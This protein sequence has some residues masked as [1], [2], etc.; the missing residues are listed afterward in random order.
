MF[1]NNQ[2][3]ICILFMLCYSLLDQ[4]I[5]YGYVLPEILIECKCADSIIFALP[6]LI[7]IIDYAPRADYI[8]IIMAE[9]RAILA[10]TKPVQVNNLHECVSSFLLLLTTV[11]AI[12]CLV[13]IFLHANKHKETCNDNLYISQ[14][15]VAW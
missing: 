2:D 10:N 4:K 14:K 5:M 1:S 15:H 11:Y 12:L 13:Y 7:T 6:T 8:D 9:F 3:A